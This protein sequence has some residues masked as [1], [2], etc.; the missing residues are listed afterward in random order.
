M[1]SELHHLSLKLC[2]KWY[3]KNLVLHL[4]VAPH[5]SSGW[6]H[7]Y[8]TQTRQAGCVNE[9]CVHRRIDICG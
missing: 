2:S 8:S 6:E 3:N 4:I 7:N 1:L 9:Q 5:L